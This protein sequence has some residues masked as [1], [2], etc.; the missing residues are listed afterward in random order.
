MSEPILTD[1]R[2]EY[3]LTLWDESDVVH[4]LM[5]QLDPDN[6]GWWEAELMVTDT[7][8][9]EEVQLYQIHALGNSPLVALETLLAKANE[10]LRA[11]L[12]VAPASVSVQQGEH[13]VAF[14][15][16]AIRKLPELNL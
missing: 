10:S 3:H 7:K 16:A 12:R 13:D 4:A 6:G 9:R 14:I 11:T 8:P 1:W 2:T 5:F 15:E